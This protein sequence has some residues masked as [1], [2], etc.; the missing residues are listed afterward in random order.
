MCIGA[1]QTKYTVKWLLCQNLKQIHV[2][3]YPGCRVQ[4][5]ATLCVERPQVLRIN[6]FPHQ[7]YLF[8]ESTILGCWANYCCC[9]I[10]LTAGAAFS[11]AA[12]TAAALLLLLLCCC[13]CFC[14]YCWCC[15][16][17]HM[18]FGRSSDKE[19]T[20][21]NIINTTTGSVLFEGGHINYTCLPTQSKVAYDMVWNTGPNATL[22]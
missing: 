3:V 13:W 6:G 12:A 18:T 11:A 5:L 14:C 22:S 15:C 1:E 19:H 7:L 16:C 2:L 4:N 20:I 10:V 21:S 17:R 9:C 8:S